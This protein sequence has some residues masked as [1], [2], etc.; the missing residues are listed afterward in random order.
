[1]NPPSKI[2]NQ[3]SKILPRHPGVIAALLFLAW[4]FTQALWEEPAVGRVRGRVLIA[5]THRPLVGARIYLTPVGAYGEGRS[6]A[7]RS[8]ADGRFSLPSVPAGSYY[9]SA[10]THAHSVSDAYLTVDE[11]GTTELTLALSR[12]EPELAL[13]QHRH[14]FATAE[15]VGFR[16]RGY[17][18]G[19]RPAG[20]DT[21]RLRVFQTRLS[22]ILQNEETARAFS[23]ATNTY[24]PP[25][26]IPG[27][28]LLEPDGAQPKLIV[29]RDIRITE[30]DRE[31]FYHQRMRLGQ[32]PPGL[33]LADVA[34]D[35]ATVF[36]WILVTDTALV[37]KRADENILAY[38]VDMNRG[39]PVGGCAV[40]A[41]R[42]GRVVARSQTDP[43]GLARL[44]VPTVENEQ[45]V[46]LVAVRG[47]D[48][49]VVD[50]SY[51]SYEE[52]GD[53]TVH[54]YTE[55]PIYRPGQRIYYKGIVRRNVEKGVRY[56][57]PEGEPV[58]VEIR[59]PSGERIQRAQ[60][61]LNN[62]G[63]YFGHVD[64]SKEALTGH[65]SLITTVRG[66][67]HTSDVVVSSYKKPEFEVTVTPGKK[68]YVRGEVIEMTVAA[69]FYFGAPVA[70]ARVRYE[71]YSEPD[72][73]AEYP[74][75]YGYEEGEDDYFRARS[76]GDYYGET[77]AD[78]ETTLDENGRAVFRFTAAPPESPDAP[79]EQVYTAYVTVTDDAKREEAGEGRAR[80]TP[81]DFRLTVSPEGYVGE[82]GRPT[83]VVVTAKDHDGNPVPNRAFDLETGYQEWK[84]GEYK[85]TPVGAQR[86]TTGP[87]G[88]AVLDVTPPRAGEL[89]LIARATDSAGRPIRGR[90]YLWAADD[91]G[92]ELQTEYADLSLL[93]DKRRYQPG[94]TARVLLNAGRV[95]QTAL[96]T[97]EGDRIYRAFQVPIQK[98]STV[99]RVPIRAEYG[100][101]V[102]LAA[103]YVRDRKFAQSEIP[104]RVHV[105][106]REL[107][108]TIIPDRLNTPTP[109]HLNALPR[110]KPGDRISYIIQTADSRGRPVACEL[111]FGVVDEAIYA[112]REDDP[113]ALR[114][115]FYPRRYNAVE[116]SYSFAVEYLGDADKA[117]PKI[118]AR[119]RFE[120]TAYWN[121]ALRTNAQG[122]ATVSFKLPD[123]LTTWRATAVAQTLDTALGREIAKV[124]ATKEFFVRVE[125]P[126]FLTE[127]DQS[128]L[129]ALVH[130]E[131]GAPQTA[132]VRLRVEGLTAGGDLTQ[133]LTLQPGQVGQAVWPVTASQMGRAKILV[134]AWT[135]KTSGATQYTDGV[136][137]YLPVKPHGREKI[138]TWAGE[139]SAAKTETETMRFDPMAIPG[140]SQLTVR[141]TPSVLTSLVG[142]LEYLIGYP[143][144]CTEQT[145][146]R[147]LPD[148]LAQ[149]VLRLH[150]V[151]PLRK[152]GTQGRWAAD[153]PD[154]VRDGLSR[155]YRFQNANGGWGWWEHDEGDPWMTA[156]V[157]YGL[158]AAQAEGYPVSASV[159]A[160]GRAAAVKLLATVRS[161]D[162]KAFLLYSLALAGDKNTARAARSQMRLARLNPP[163]LACLVLLDRHLGGGSRAAFEALGRKAVVDGAMLHWEAFGQDFYGD[164][165]DK[166][167]TALGLRALLAVNPQ[168]P[169][170]GPAMRW[171]MTQRTGEYWGSTRDTSFVLAALCDYLAA[172]PPGSPDGAVRISLN[173]RPYRTY[174]LTPDVVNEPELALRIPASDL[175]AGKNE[176]TLERVGG[177]SVIFYS[178]TLRQT[179]AMEDIPAESPANIGIKREYLRLLPRKADHNSWSLQTEPTGNQLRSGDRIRVR[180]TLTIPRDM[181]YVL[182]E[183]PFP[184]GCEVTERGSAE[185]T[186]EWGYWWSSIDVRDDKIAFFARTLT[187]GE[188]VIEYNLRAQTPGVYHTLPT[189]LQGMYAPET[190]G[191]SAEARVEVR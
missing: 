119:K 164:W 82:P 190:R 187:A 16:V 12:S 112:L 40:R 167:T 51:Y 134:T 6:R 98:R 79:Q 189:L 2:E 15:E 124:I 140:A 159:L 54:T 58:T 44:T 138:E 150:G 163:G 120:D 178:V 48:E 77:A 106:R 176:V 92:G 116:T 19:D 64:L 80:V 151:S 180:L 89:R 28:L 71:V 14:V 62:Y 76:Y 65:Y 67:R 102:F 66:E 137:T 36:T 95:G 113:T 147:F 91:A 18:D 130:N 153:L 86:G 141:I 157:L 32:L 4:T 37:V 182:I 172:L 103:C 1:M 171:L 132:L 52:R 191:E 148:I 94:E 35:S 84:D 87:D 169:R 17:V 139:L 63:S 57:V 144:G 128:R 26:G 90:A 110:Y 161:D 97:I 74:D 131:T 50:R 109:D 59:D 85:F 33:Y 146:S 81:G 105:A 179:V 73:A 166:L 125:T 127:R 46:M 156:Y 184:S 154:M 133:T 21:L 5:D 38:T 10:S 104:L 175:I 42:K 170:V 68:R 107:R 117:E 129:L 118:E 56:G 126:R 30:A 27:L 22:N 7:A 9:A 93:T 174:T 160:R 23:E 155:L 83:P 122:R 121:P 72:W 185:E 34:H 39:A 45:Q 88:R 108:V 142:A 111:S 143:Y 3:Q 20:Q 115:A 31:G 55:R 145:M 173:G 152:G 70:G 100:P 188:H 186:V 25:P 165:D 168:D 69:E 114:D 181:A 53:Y 75:D 123:N 99:L 43:Q 101:N 11:G 8:G 24:N 162:T 78:G 183:D 41:Y 177:S 149:R 61:T 47:E 49:A 96:L 158:A 13:M 135:P 29:Q 136:E 60:Y